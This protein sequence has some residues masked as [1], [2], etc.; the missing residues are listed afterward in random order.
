MYKKG[1][2]NLAFNWLLG[3]VEMT[4]LAQNTEHEPVSIRKKLTVCL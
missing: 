1:T 3:M 2:P 4:L